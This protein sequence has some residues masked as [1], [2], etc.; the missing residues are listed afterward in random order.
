MN[1][2]IKHLHT[3]KPS[4]NHYIV[5]AVLAA[6][7]V[8][9]YLYIDKAEY[10]VVGNKI[11]VSVVKVANVDFQNVIEALGTAKANESVELASQG[12]HKIKKIYFD[13]NAFVRAGDVVL[14]FE[15]DE[16]RAQ[17]L[18]SKSKYR[19]TKR[20]KKRI[21]TLVEKNVAPKQQFDQKVTEMEVSKQQKEELKAR[22]AQLTI[23][24]PFDGQLGIWKYSVGAIVEPSHVIN[25]IDD[26][27]IIKVD[28]HVPSL[29]ITMLKVGA[30]V[31]ATSDALHSKEF[32]GIIKSVD[33]RVDDATRS[34]LVRAIVDNPDR[35]IKPGLLI[36][37]II[38]SDSKNS[39]AVPEESVFHKG[40]EHFVYVLDRDSG[41]VQA[42]KVVVGKRISGYA[43]ILDGISEGDEVVVHGLLKLKDG[44]KVDVAK[45]IEMPKIISHEGR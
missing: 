22:L 6:I 35:L 36:K 28:F 8:V 41:A 38:V 27:K 33:T 13:D 1:H 19:E 34:I 5:A 45:E 9:A 17:L 11:P 3:L 12:S 15:Q 16:E 30:P 24:A 18:A 23:K 40:Q 26:I 32:S 44:S 25:T 21:E 29:H 20:E 10:A 37:V 14:E 2:K 43:E 7:L 31:L 39:L 4:R 42:R